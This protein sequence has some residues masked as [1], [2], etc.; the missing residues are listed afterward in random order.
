ML[1]Q[2][3]LSVKI[4]AASEW[5]GGLAAG[6][7]KELAHVRYDRAME[8]GVAMDRQDGVEPHWV[9]HW[10]G[11]RAVQASSPTGSSIGVV[12]EPCSP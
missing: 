7:T 9:Q 3:Q 12:G 6:F 5:P 1:A 4:Y 8:N 10:R 2:W 11:G